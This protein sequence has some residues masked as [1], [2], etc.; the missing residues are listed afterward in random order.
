V[1]KN[2][3]HFIKEVTQYIRENTDIAVLGLSGVADSTLVAILCKEALGKENVIGVHMPCTDTDLDKF[4]RKSQQ[5][6]SL[7]EIE[8]VYI[9]ISYMVNA[10][11]IEVLED[12]QKNV[13]LIEGNLR[14]RVRM[15]C[16]YGVA[17]MTSATSD[18]RVRV[19]GTG[20]LSEDFIG[21]D[22]KGGD[23][24]ADFF[25]IGNLYKSEVYQLL[26]YYRDKGVITEDLIDKVPSAGLWVG[27]TDEQELGYSYDEMEPAIRKLKGEAVEV[28]D[29]I[30]VFVKNRYEQNKHKH[31]APPVFE[32]KECITHKE[33]LWLSD[34][35]GEKYIPYVLNLIQWAEGEGLIIFANN[36]KE[37][38]GNTL[39]GLGMCLDNSEPS[40]VCLNCTK[41]KRALMVLAHEIGHYL[42][43]QRYFIKQKIDYKDCSAKDR[44]FMAYFLGWAVLRKVGADA[45][46]TKDMWRLDFFNLLSGMDFIRSYSDCVHKYFKPFAFLGFLSEADKLMLEKR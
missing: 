46:I 40:W 36:E 12:C 39:G 25:P 16:L 29:E 34:K 8:Q 24:L 10:F 30:L 3:E 37:L 9:N 2:L 27:Q 1:L 23:A 43:G 33:P 41:A 13:D 31:E 19:I 35:Q 26:E 22:T 28:S 18:K 20:N 38:K 32:Y 6:A 5:L 17:N 21:Y 42:G 11:K 44:E 7:L 45:V 4:N 14:A 15:T